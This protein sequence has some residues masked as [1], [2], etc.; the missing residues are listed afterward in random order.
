M[1]VAVRTCQ[2]WLSQ[3]SRI[4][5]H[6]RIVNGWALRGSCTTAALRCIGSGLYPRL[7]SFVF[8]TLIRRGVSDHPQP[9]AP[10]PNGPSETRHPRERERFSTHPYTV[11]GTVIGL[12]ALVV[13]VLVW[14][15][16]ERNQASKTTSS[17]S[18][19]SV[20]PR[21]DGTSTE[22]QPPSVLPSVSSAP[23]PPNFV[24]ALSELESGDEDTAV[25]GVRDLGFIY[26]TAAP[27]LRSR[28]ITVLVQYISVA[29]P[30]MPSQADSFGY[31]LANPPPNYPAGVSAALRIL[32][33][34]NPADVGQVVNLSGIN[35]AYATL[36]GLDFQNVNFDNDLLCRVIS[37]RS[38]FQGASFDGAD[39]RFSIIKYPTGLTAEQLQAVYSLYKANLPAGITAN[40]SIAGLIRK[41]P[42]LAPGFAL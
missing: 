32:G 24:E 18:V 38:D 39:L 23:L 17:S 1:T 10:S 9:S 13:T 19:I 36:D 42:A 5:R 29:A 31:C 21:S 25:I 34:R 37:F 16:W 3:K 11:I 4:A 20:P 12:L 35:L 8:I 41:D 40:K 28:V 26:D 2:R 6:P 33:N 22:S 14:A 15:P 30:P 7:T 27:A